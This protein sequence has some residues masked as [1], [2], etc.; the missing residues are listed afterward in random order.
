[1]LVVCISQ[2][3]LRGNILLIKDLFGVL[4][5]THNKKKLQ[6]EIESVLGVS[7]VNSY[8]ERISPCGKMQKI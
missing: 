2:E 8:H 1:M 4:T 6:L 3:E 7:T 5:L